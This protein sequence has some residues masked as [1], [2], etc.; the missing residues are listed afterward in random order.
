MATC[1]FAD[2]A[3]LTTAFPQVVRLVPE[4]WLV[5]VVPPAQVGEYVVSLAGAEYPYPAQV[6]DDAG[7]VRD[8]LLAALSLQMLAAVSPTG[9]ASVILDALSPNGLDVTATGPA[10]DTIT[11][12]LVSGGDSNEAFRLFWLER[13]KCGLPPCCVVTCP[14]DYT[15]MHA[16]LAAH[17]IFLF[18]NLGPTGL[19]SG[20]F[21]RMRLG[22]AELT[23]GANLWAA[24]PAAGDLA[25]TD[26]G[27][28]YL[29]VRA[30][31]VF[32]ILCV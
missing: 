8:G 27:K 7:A 29:S 32:G 6:G 31:Y 10:P 11:A 24:N 14:G 18:G 20:D 16:A 1:V 17:Y 5:T 12:T 15:L 13:A 26:P 4:R 22:P 25:G 23:K 30:R 28:L 2:D 19:A 21:E 3:Y 9:A